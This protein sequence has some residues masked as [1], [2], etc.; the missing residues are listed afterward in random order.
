MAEMYDQP[1][2]SSPPP[3]VPSALPPRPTLVEADEISFFLH[4][5]VHSSSPCMSSD[6]ANPMP[7][8]SSVVAV[9]PPPL[10]SS[11]S[12]PTS[13]VRSY[14]SLPE[15]HPRPCG[16]GLVSDSDC[17]VGVGSSM[18]ESSAAVDSSSVIL[19]S[20]GVNLK[21]TTST[22]S[23]G[24]ADCDVPSVSA[25]RR[26]VPT[27]NDIDDY[28]CESE[29]VRRRLRHRQSQ[30]HLVFLRKEAELP[31]FIICPKSVEVLDAQ[32]R[33]RRINEKMKAL[34]NLIPNSNKT[35]KASMLDE[36]IEYLK[37]LQLQVQMLSMRNGLS[38]YPMYLPG[39]LQSTQLPQMQMGFGDG[40]RSL[41]MNMGTC[42][43]PVNQEDS[44]Q[45]AFSL[46][47]QPAPLQK[48]G[49][50]PNVTNITNSE[51][52]FGADLPV[53][54]HNGPFQLSKA[55]QEFHGEGLLCQHRSDMR[56]SVRNSSENNKPMTTSTLPFDAQSLVSLEPA[57]L[58]ACV[59]HKEGSQEVL[60]KDVNG[61]Q[62]LIQHLHRLEEVCRIENKMTPDC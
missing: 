48:P 14:E 31:K 9:P 33:R 4:H 25:K 16:S 12:Q 38:L 27:N 51:S 20:A 40:E 44:T 23:A 37:Q 1:V 43:M 53:Q 15:A 54:A 47:N 7:F 17:R 10:F 52:S 62:I 60:P 58:G 61:N 13:T 59:L 22:T 56:H 18:A 57:S 2:C 26:K 21:E 55:S 49:V 45:N 5:L 39:V 35:D 3:P 29:M 46:S 11:F 28:D 6:R 24:A 19:S 50:L 8:S 30:L 34:Q 36:A 41:H 32:R 42:T